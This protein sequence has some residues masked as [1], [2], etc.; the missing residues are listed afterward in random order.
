M[1]TQQETE[2]CD[3]MQKI[4]R[5]RIIEY[6]LPLNEYRCVRNSLYG[7]SIPDTA[8]EGH[9]IRTYYLN[10]ALNIMEARF[11]N[12]NGHFSATQWKSN[13]DKNFWSE[14]TE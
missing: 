1:L 9:Y 5:D 3:N 10:F 8:K 11:P 6:N 12:D 7:D 14:D 13:L 4:M 2:F